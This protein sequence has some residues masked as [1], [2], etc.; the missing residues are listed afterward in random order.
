MEQKDF[1]LK[2]KKTISQLIIDILAERISVQ[3]GIKKFPRGIEDDSVECSLHAI[4]H[5][6][7][8]EDY[9]KQ[10]PEYAVEQK[11]YL[12]YIAN[13][14]QQ[15]EDM[16]INIIEEYKKYYETAPVISK[17]GIIYMLK[18]LFRLTI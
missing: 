11:D 3:D 15:G 16:P 13:L 7:A 1:L 2:A 12:E 10:D 6:E 9:R 8:D 5:Y 14:F 18:N 17:K 4:L